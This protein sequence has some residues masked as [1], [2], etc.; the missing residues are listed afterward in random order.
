[1]VNIPWPNLP[2]FVSVFRGNDGLTNFAK[3]KNNLLKFVFGEDVNGS[4]GWQV[5]L[6]QTYIKFK[7]FNYLKDTFF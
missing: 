7:F 6:K 4:H 5:I 3:Y 1:M 2:E